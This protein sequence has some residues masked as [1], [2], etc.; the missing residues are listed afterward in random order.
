MMTLEGQTGPTPQGPE[1]G[2]LR[3]LGFILGWWGITEGVK[4]GSKVTRLSVFK[5][6]LCFGRTNWRWLEWET[7]EKAVPVV[8][9]RRQ[10]RTQWC[11]RGRECAD[12]RQ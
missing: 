1:A 6:S 10:A 9:N 7:S 11:H 12:Q 2:F 4:Q 3:D 8:Q 5:S